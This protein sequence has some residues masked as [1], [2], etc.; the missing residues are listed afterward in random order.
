MT[1]WLP[2]FGSKKQKQK[3]DVFGCHM[4]GVNHNGSGMC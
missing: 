4:I 1:L 2:L 3:P